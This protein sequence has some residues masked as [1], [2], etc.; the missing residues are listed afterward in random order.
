MKKV[1]QV[2]LPCL[3]VIL[4]LFSA[5]FVVAA[6]NANVSADSEAKK[7]T[8]V[9]KGPKQI[10]FDKIFGDWKALLI[11]LQKLREEYSSASSERKQEIAGQY[12]KLIEKGLDMEPKLAAAAEAAYRENPG[13]DVDLQNFLGVTATG[14]LMT[15]NYEDAYRLAQLLMEGGCKDPSLLPIAGI[16]AF[17]IGQFEDAKKYL[18]QAQNEGIDI[19]TGQQS[20]D[21]L[22][23][24]FL[25]GSSQFIKNEKAEQK[26]R[27]AE[28]NADDLP[29]I[30]FETDEGNITIELFENEAPMAAANFISLVEDGFYDELGFHRVLPGFMAQGG[31]PRGD[32]RGDPGYSIPCEVN[33]PTARKHFRGSLSMAHAGPNT[34]GSQFF[35]TFVPTAFLDGK[36][37]VFGRVIDGIDVLPKIK[38]RDPENPK[39]SLGAPTKI[40]SARVL[41]KR[42]H[43]YKPTKVPGSEKSSKK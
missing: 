24:I 15:D 12:E 36:H 17:A 35:L 40:L 39:E 29:R 8:D 13:Q 5:A 30:L 27:E 1:F 2:W 14:C 42:D 25:G 34:G 18:T 20:L 11:E 6:D 21:G 23:D 9:Q 26:L 7:M 3:A 33:K 37:T 28:A 10:A 32:G 19:K 38:R 41:R 4:V 22:V 43:E 31:C 16:S